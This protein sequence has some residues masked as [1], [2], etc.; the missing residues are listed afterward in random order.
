M[1]TAAAPD[2]LLV[3]NPSATHVGGH[4]AAGAEAAGVP[5]AVCDSRE[6]YVGL[7]WRRRLAWRAGGR[8][9]VALRRFSRKVVDA[10]RA[11]S[12]RL[13][14]TTGLAPVDR[15]ALDDIG[16]AGVVR[17]NFLTDDP[18]NPAHRAPWFFRALGGY[19]AVFS[20]RTA[21]LDDLRALGG[22]AVTYLPFGY[23]PAEHFVD[24]VPN[25]RAAGFTADVMFAGGADADRLPVM[26]SLIEAG[27]D[28]ALYGGYWN[29][30]HAT[31]AHARGVLDAP[32]LRHAVSGAK[33][34]LCLVRRA[35]RDGHAMRTYEVAAMGGCLLVERTPEHERLFGP[36][37]ECVAYFASMPEAIAALRRLLADEPLRRRLAAACRTRVTTGA[38]TYADRLA[39]MLRT[40]GARQ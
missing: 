20:P 40:T 17:A 31:R 24:P 16:A 10:V 8:R 29:R 25:D 27:F 35:N 1:V 12:P 5:I 22:P 28:V 33:V 9:P 11:T 36:D 6:A 34:C 23:S 4:L 39:T 19:D 14:L 37:G 18:W 32:G 15:D 7:A 3:G 21:N 2:V 30:H 38:N 26:G 13:V